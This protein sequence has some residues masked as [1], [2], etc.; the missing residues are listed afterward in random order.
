MDLNSADKALRWMRRDEK[1]HARFEGIAILWIVFSSVWTILL[2]AGMAFLYRRRDMPILRIRGLLLSFGSV[3]LLHLYWIAVQWVYVVALLF[4]PAV[5]FWIMSIWLPFGIALFHASNSRFLYVAKS[6]KNLFASKNARPKSERVKKQG[7]IGRYSN[8][9]YT[10][11]MLVLVGLGMLFQLLLTTFMFLVSR[12]FHDSFG[13]SGTEVTGTESERK[14][15]A[16]KGWEWW[17]SIVWQLVWAWVIAPV[18]LWKSR[19]IRDTQGWRVQTIACCLANLHAAPMW[20]I[21]LYLPAMAPVNNVFVPPQWIALSIMIIEVFTIF[22]PCWEVLRHQSLRQET[23]DIIS[24]W[25][26]KK[27]TIAISSAK[28]ASTRIT[29]ATGSSLTAWSK[30]ESIKSFNSSETI[31]TMGALECMLERNP[32]PLQQFSA[33]HD[34]SGENIAFLRAVAEW[35]SSLP[36][37]FRGSSNQEQY[38]AIQELIH[39]R[40]NSALRIYATFI[41]TR[42]AE[43][44]VNLSSQNLKS[45]EDI[46]EVSARTLYGDKRPVDPA[47]PF[48]SFNMTSLANVNSSAASAHGSEDGIFTTSRDVNASALWWGDIPESFNGSIFDDAE[49]SIKYLVLTNTWPKFVKAKRN[50]LE[51]MYS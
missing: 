25:E 39:E 19:N 51:S 14:A 29:I 33:L 50:S 40:F 18:I 31:F 36:A 41:S 48:E 13:I 8:L 43:F 7:L 34:F 38:S 49:A 20:L 23:L 9:N 16:R 17:P 27:T 10:K 47:L 15:A 5:E 28:S 4:P 32:E 46:F 42:D 44:Q 3:V 11:R 1:P 24:Q 26:S 30:G 21:A 35:K 2:V 22:L 37:S 45:L 12:K 6:Q